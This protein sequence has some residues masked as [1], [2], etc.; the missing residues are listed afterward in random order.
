[1]DAQKIMFY[2]SRAKRAL[3]ATLLSAVSLVGQDTTGKIE[4]I[5]HDPSGAVIP[6][7]SV[8]VLNLQNGLSRVGTSDEA[9]Y[10]SFSLLPPANYRLIAQAPNFKKYTH[11]PLAL[12]VNQNLRLA[13]VLQVGAPDESVEVKAAPPLVDSASN[14]IGKVTSSSEF[15]DLPLNG[16]NFSQLG[17]LQAG[18]A[19]LTLGLAQAG[20]ALRSGQSFSINGL[21]PES[22]NF[23]IDGARNINN[24]DAGFALNPPLDSIEEFRILTGGAPAEFGGNVASNTNLVTRSGGNELHGTAYD[25]LRNDIFDARNF[26]ASQVEPLKQNQ[27]GTTLGGPLRKNGTF[28]FGYYEGLRNRQGITRTSTVPTLLERQGDFSQS[29]DANGNIQPL[30]N[31]LFGSAYPS[32]QLPAGQ[33]NPISQKLMTL[34]PEPNIGRNLFNSTEAGR[35]NIDQFGI[36]VDHRFSSRDDAFFRYIFAQGSSYSPFSINGAGVPGFPVGD[37]LRIQNFLVSNTHT[38]SMD[39]ISTSRVAYFQHRFDFDQRFNH[40]S[41][42]SF[43]FNISPTFPASVGP[44]FF[45]FSGGLAAFGNP[46]TGPRDTLQRSLEFS[47]AFA[48]THQSHAF[49]VGENTAT[50][51]SAPNKELPATVFL[52]LPRSPS[53]SLS[54]IFWQALRWSSFNPAGFGR[55]I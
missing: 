10:F 35:N 22:N 33:I 12:M 34:I 2:L 24:V 3:L 43:G 19:P 38:F 39:L 6:H 54:P 51:G 29:Y 30:A 31:Y 50:I 9:G 53:A 42:S 36:R 41:P 17:V 26:F 7:G 11:Q 47:H 49:K 32:N 28:F 44:P 48:W 25:F 27:F 37:N 5:L 21:R 18:A 45:Q 46:I 1:M 16:R 23:L 14:V 55:G 20:G 52:S 13:I 15:Y 4:G 40:D 8:E